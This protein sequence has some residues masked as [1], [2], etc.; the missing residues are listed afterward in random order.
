MKLIATD[1]LAANPKK[2]LKDLNR[3]GSLVITENGHPR[4]ILTPTSDETVLEDIQE[5]VRARARR[6]VS[7]IRRE[8][9]RRGLD[10]LTIAEIDR[11]IAAARKSRR[12]RR[13]E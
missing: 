13:P 4:G 10:R 7:E 11:E 12:R 5:Q 9:A 8:S 2:I 1:E 3:E 6:A